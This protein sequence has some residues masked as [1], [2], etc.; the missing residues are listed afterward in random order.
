MEGKQKH[1]A[2]SFLFNDSAE[3]VRQN[4][5]GRLLSSGLHLLALPIGTVPP[6]PHVPILTTKNLDTCKRCIVYVGQTN[7]PLG[8]LSGRL[9]DSDSIAHGSVI[10]FTESI[11]KPNSSTANDGIVI[12]QEVAHDRAV[13]VISS[14]QVSLARWCQ[15]PRR[16]SKGKA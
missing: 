13:Q 7:Q 16:N 5:L 11:L 12:S 2:T 8:Y 6:A 14:C 3:C 9:M 15:K 1:V 4:I 10:Q